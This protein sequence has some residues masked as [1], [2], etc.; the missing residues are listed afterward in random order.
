[1]PNFIPHIPNSHFP[2]KNEKNVKRENLVRDPPDL[3]GVG[4]LSVLQLEVEPDPGGG[5][6]HRVGEEQVVVV[7]AF[8]GVRGG[9]V[10]HQDGRGATDLEKGE[11]NKTHMITLMYFFVKS[12]W[13]KKLELASYS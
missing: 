11:V 12:T 5:A 9:G 7:G 8:R 3:E 1:M 6:G 2:P 4:G 10:G 13:I